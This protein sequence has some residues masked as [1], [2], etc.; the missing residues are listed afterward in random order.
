MGVLPDVTVFPL[1]YIQN[2]TDAL[3]KL[4]LDKKSICFE[5]TAAY[6]NGEEQTLD[7]FHK[8]LGDDIEIFGGTAGNGLKDK[9]TYVAQ[10]GHVFTNACVFAF[11]NIEMDVFIN[12]EDI[13]KPTSKVFTV[14]EA[15]PNKRTIFTLDN[16][17]A[18]ETLSNVLSIPKNTLKDYLT[19]HPLGHII[20]N[21]QYI[22]EPVDI[23]EDG[24]ITFFAQVFKHSKVAL[25]EENQLDS[26]FENTKKKVRENVTKPTFSL[27][28]NCLARS[29]H[30]EK[31][32]GL[33]KF[34]NSLK[35]YAGDYL[36]FSGFGEQYSTYHF[37]QSM[38]SA[39]FLKKQIKLKLNF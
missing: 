21:K 20:N 12:R 15:N 37:N 2:V 1:Q 4:P 8:V 16:L 33:D 39:T 25:F 30:F 7:T 13:F 5:I 18:A 19:N 11:L 24:S 23:N 35:E 22:I 3:A 34:N 36:G 9:T 26:V 28:V 32:N 38:I 6:K 17:P 29:T 31:I 27:I 10:N 14:T